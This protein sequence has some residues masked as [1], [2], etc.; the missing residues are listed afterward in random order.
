MFVFWKNKSLK[1]Q[2]NT[3]IQALPIR[4]IPE[5]VAIASSLKYTP[6]TTFLYGHRHRCSLLCLQMV[7]EATGGREW[8]Q[9]VGPQA[10][11]SRFPS[12]I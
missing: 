2:A 8:Y 1:F 4:V 7:S 5:P 3:I 10:K 11:D 9:R 6:T 12:W